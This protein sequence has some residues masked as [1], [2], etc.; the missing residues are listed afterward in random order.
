MGHP[1]ENIQKGELTRLE[2]SGIVYL[3]NL[4]LGITKIK[5]K[6]L[7]RGAKFHFWENGVDIP[8]PILL[9]K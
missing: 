4:D 3:S 1:D 7:F 8:F 2:L 9:T 5:F 6:T